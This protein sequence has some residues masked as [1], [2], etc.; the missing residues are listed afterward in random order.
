MEE[1]DLK[2]IGEVIDQRFDRKFS[3]GFQR[4]FP[5]AFRQGFPEAFQLEFG[6]VWDKN[7]S[8]ALED[9]HGKLEELEMKVNNLPTKSYLDNLQ[10]F[11][12]VQI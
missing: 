5:T 10:I 3:E 12:K 6:Q 11:P 7:L 9:I 4:E 8:P 1:K 2:Q